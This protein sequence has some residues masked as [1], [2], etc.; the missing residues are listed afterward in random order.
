MLLFYGAG[1][2]KRKAWVIYCLSGRLEAEQRA[3]RQDFPL[4]GSIILDE[5]P[6]YSRLSIKPGL[7]N[8][9]VTPNSRRGNGLYRRDALLFHIVARWLLSNRRAFWAY[10]GFAFE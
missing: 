8:F 7:L 5:K 1:F 4:C 2:P 10:V 6:E 3:R 9:P